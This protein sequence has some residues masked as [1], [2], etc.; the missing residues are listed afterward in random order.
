MAIELAGVSLEAQGF[1]EYIKKLDAIEKKN[2]KVFDTQ[3]KGTDK[4]FTEVTKAARDYERQLK[5]TNDAQRKAAQEAKKLAAAQ[6]TARATQQQAALSAANAIFQATKQVA[7]FV[8]ET[9]QLAAQ[10][11]GSQIGLQNLAASF[12]Q[13]GS[14]IQSA[15]QTA[16]KGTI[17]GLDSINAAN[18]ALLLGVAKTPAE[19]EKLTKVSLTLGRTLGLTGKQSLEQFTTA[20]GRR[21]LLIL[22]NFGISANQVNAE[23]EKLAQQNFGKINSELSEAQKNTTFMEAA[24]KIAS[25]SA[26]A[27]GEEAGQAQASFERLVA[28]S[29]DLR[30]TLGEALRP[31]GTGISDTL[32]QAAVTAQ[33]ALAFISAG[34]VGTASIVSSA[35]ER[36]GT[37]FSNLGRIIKGEPIKAIQSFDS[38]LDE[39]AIKAADQF[40]SVAST[41][42]GVSFDEPTKSAM[43][44]EQEIE[45]AT[46]SLKGYEQALKQAENLQL[47]FARSAEDAALKLA[48]ANED[49]ARKQGRQVNKLEEKQAKDR[50]KILDDQ[51]KELENFDKDS[52][53]EVD[54]AEK[55]ISKER[56]KA[57]ESRLKAQKKLQDRLRQQEDRFRLSQ[58]QGERRFQ[59]ADRRLRAEGDILALQE[60]RE[61]R[62]LTLQEEKENFG[63]QQKETSKSGKEQIKEQE[64]VSNDRVNEIKERIE[65]ERA[66][67]LAGFDAELADFQQ[68]QIEE[69]AN[70]QARFAEQAEDRK[71]A[72]ARQEEDRRI[73][74]TRQLEDLGRSL[75]EQE[76]V[77]KEGSEKV[78]LALEGVF[79][80]DGSASQIMTGF[81]AKT[82][83]EFRDLFE[84]LN[85]IVT[86][87]G[88]ILDLS[89]VGL[90]PTRPGRRQSNASGIPSFKDGGVVPGPSGSPQLVLAHG[91]EL[92]SNQQQ[93]QAM[94]APVIPSQTLTI[95]GGLNVQGSGFGEANQQIVDQTM[96]EMTEAWQIALNRLARRN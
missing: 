22:D 34:A 60:L 64:K 10:F 46:V 3:F 8:V 87:E 85:E 25:Q 93:Q 29:Q 20:L 50:S 70:L 86:D 96:N 81:T 72:L 40:K 92:I 78:A 32:S 75:A 21:S 89:N 14:E 16:S 44:F 35:W 19:F 56:Q 52:K 18:Q 26:A 12:G 38:I 73:S 74:Q 71:I 28:T 23:I 13:S 58:I 5:K 84:N 53:K 91:G 48:R 4:S 31:I 43:E 2:R 77:T 37:T 88:E 1:N 51:I 62:A 47:S 63:Q 90:P 61:D 59:L 95:Q 80:I 83:S 24:L 94:T 54:K 39:A 7:R 79:G 30:V 6:K 17:S 76:G 36:V 45:Q 33:K 57:A 27:I 42:A 82:E 55:D 69:R 9:S 65:S 49:I 67:L 15:I 66:E 41:I 11:K 68:Q